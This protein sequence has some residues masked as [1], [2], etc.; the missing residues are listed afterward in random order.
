MSK[1]GNKET[2]QP[3]VAGAFYPDDPVTL[4]KTLAEMYSEAKKKTLPG[5]PIAII[6]PHAGYV[7]SGK[8]AAMAYKQLEGQQYDVVVVISPSHTVFFQG[9]SVY[10]GGAYKTP[11]GKIE[12]DR[13]LAE[14]IGSIHPLVYMSN[15]GHTGG[16]IRGEHSLEVQLPF[17]Q[18]VLGN[19]KLVAVV[20][21][22]QEEATCRALGEVLASVLSKKN[23]LI[24]ASSDLSHFHGEKEARKLDGIVQQA[25]EAYDPDKLLNVL[26][27]GRGEACGGG[28]IAAAMI[29][30]RKLGGEKVVVADYSTSAKT[31]GDFSEVV[32]YLSA[33]IVSSK[34][35]PK[36]DS[37]M[38]TP[39]SKK[40]AGFKK[41][42]KEFLLKLAHDAIAA[43]VNNE[44]LIFAEP[45]SRILCEKRGAF[46]TIKIRGN[47][48]GCIGLI[49][50]AKPLY[51]TVIEMAR[52]AA[53]DD[54]R[55]A[56][57][58]KDELDHIE[59]EISA[60]TPLVRVEDINEIE[61]GRDGLMIVLQMHSG[62]LLPQVAT[63]NHW[64]R[65][66]F[67]EQTCLKAGLPKNSYKDKAAQIY[68]F[69][70]EVF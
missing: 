4:T 11:L 67:L 61:V 25:V 37:T 41:E 2:R 58:S 55:F 28:P 33:L 31:T 64:N 36:R 18:Q 69:S 19:F 51:E 43:G 16:S 47:L 32:G 46:V 45:T 17:L 20:L 15:Q 62:L 57:L 56:P 38:G 65:T 39:I 26:T 8:T 21:G 54:P 24:V 14:K 52:S 59:I 48:R 66:A 7:Y 44:K 40:W 42:D 13:E 35:A 3:A 23:S 1:D 34:A 63:E 53:F 60:L 30:T 10:D 5:R 70:A 9:A 12:I 6:A 50:A 68:R 27:S 29:A 49:R 22:D